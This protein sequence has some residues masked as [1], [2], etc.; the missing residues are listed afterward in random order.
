MRKGMKTAVNGLSVWALVLWLSV[1]ILGGNALPV[2]A[3][4]SISAQEVVVYSSRKEHLIKPVFDAFTAETGIKVSYLTGKDNA[5]I[6]RVKAEGA[7]TPADLLM[8]VDAGNL[9]YAASQD[10]FQPIQTPLVENSIPAH[11]RDPDGMWTGL[12]IRAR[13]I[14]YSTERVKPSEL[15]SYEQLAEPQWKGR[16]CLRTAKKVYTKSLVSALLAHHGEQQTG[17]VI[18]GWVKNL[19]AVPMAK[20]SHIMDA[21]VAGQCDVGLVNTYYFGRL[22]EKHPAVPLKLFW[23]N[24]QSTGTHVNVSGAGIL[25]HAKHPE[26]A[27][28]LLGWLASDSAQALF[29]RLN[30]E[31][32]ANP[33]I[34][35]DPLVAAWG[36]FEQDTLNLQKVGAL[37]ADAVRLMQR[38]GYR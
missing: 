13:T 14:V 18:Q 36:T 16:L 4:D 17:Q 35:S 15:S 20:D 38:N 3:A 33:E 9:W 11:L 21:I 34:K 28:T 10:V 2:Q 27:N 23:A 22:Q 29:A 12:S 24:Q 5:L 26:L 31:F 25:K 7:A 8:T 1:P 37:Q 30:K 19:A 6:E 32:P